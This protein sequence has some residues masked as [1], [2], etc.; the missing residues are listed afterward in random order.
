MAVNPFPDR[1]TLPWDQVKDE[2]GQKVLADAA[3]YYD[4]LDSLEIGRTVLGGP[5]LEARFNAP[6]GNVY[7]VD[8]LA[9]RYREWNARAAQYHA[10]IGLIRSSNAAPASVRYST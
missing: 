10:T 9:S 6:W 4:G 2:I 5:D 7:H 1:D 3:Q 8:P